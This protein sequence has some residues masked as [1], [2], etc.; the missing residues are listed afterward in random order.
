M[1]IENIKYR[2]TNI[3]HIKFIKGLKIKIDILYGTKNIFN[4]KLK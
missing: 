1:K 2:G 4:S 3:V